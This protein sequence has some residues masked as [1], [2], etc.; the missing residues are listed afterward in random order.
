MFICWVNV[1]R[2]SWPPVSVPLS[3]SLKPVPPFDGLLLL[4]D[5]LIN[6]VDFFVQISPPGHLG[7]PTGPDAA[8]EVDHPSSNALSPSVFLLAQVITSRPV[9][10]DPPVPSNQ[11]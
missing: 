11:L 6:L 10:N 8:G 9:R 7:C 3:L 2:L 4:C 5:P 1:W